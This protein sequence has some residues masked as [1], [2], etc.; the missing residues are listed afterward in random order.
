MQNEDGTILI[1][2]IVEDFDKDVKVTF[3]LAPKNINESN[4]SEVGYTVTNDISE[5]VFDYKLN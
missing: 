2:G 4:G 5:E 3:T 1:H